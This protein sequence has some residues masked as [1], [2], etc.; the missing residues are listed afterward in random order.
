MFVMAVALARDYYRMGI[1]RYLPTTHSILNRNG[2]PPMRL[3]SASQSELEY[4][5]SPAVESLLAAVATGFLDGAS[6]L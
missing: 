3:C 1:F 4:S 6:E 5:S 2:N